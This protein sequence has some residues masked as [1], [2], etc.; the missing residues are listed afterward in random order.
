MQNDL[1]PLVVYVVYELA[2]YVE[3]VFTNKAKAYALAASLNET[4]QDWQT[5]A[6]DD[7]FLGMSDAEARA[8]L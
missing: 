6:V 4:A 8:A 7:A 3:G 2:G 1:P 5:F